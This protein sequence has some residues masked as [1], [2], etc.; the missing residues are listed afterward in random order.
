MPRYSSIR[1]SLN[2]LRY[3]QGGRELSGGF[4]SGPGPAGAGRGSHHHRSGRGAGETRMLVRLAIAS[5]ETTSSTRRFCWRPTAVS[6]DTTGRDSPKPRAVMEPAGTACCIR[7][8][9]TARARRSDSSW[10]YLPVRRSDRLLP[11]NPPAPAGGQPGGSALRSCRIP[12]TAATSH[13]VFTRRNPIGPA[14]THRV[15]IS[16]TRRRNRGRQAHLHGTAVAGPVELA[17]HRRS[18]R[19]WLDRCRRAGPPS[20][21]AAQVPGRCRGLYNGE[22]SFRLHA[23]LVHYLVRW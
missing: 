2:R 1:D 8:S 5:P 21:I 16:S 7:Y 11:V 13:R 19:G 20:R 18:R 12:L 3:I 15:F 10:L 9:L 17:R 23:S 14:S 6:F 22:M 4:Q